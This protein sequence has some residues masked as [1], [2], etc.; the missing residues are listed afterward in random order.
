M[1]LDQLAP[2]KD[3][4]IHEVRCEETAL[5]KH[6][7][8]MGLTPGTEVTMIKAA[9]MGDPL[10]IRTRGYELTLRKAD[11]AKIELRDIHEAHEFRRDSRCLL[12]IPHPGMG[13]GG[14][15]LREAIASGDIAPELA[16]ARADV[17]PAAA[18]Q[19]PELPHA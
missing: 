9:P 10:E 15:G 5:R 12:T 17:G 2:G 13:E 14:S 16:P 11:A 6:I 8:D 4:I 1:T 18:S 7:L 3:A 19:P